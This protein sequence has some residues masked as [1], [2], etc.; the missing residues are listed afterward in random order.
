MEIGIDQELT[1]VVYTAIFGGRDKLQPPG[2]ITPGW[3][4]VCFSDE[5]LNCEGWQIKVIPV[6][7][8][9][10]DPKRNSGRIK[11]LSHEYHPNVEITL[12]M[13]ANF[14]ITCDLNQLVKAAL[15]DHDIA[16]FKHPGWNCIYREADQVIHFGLDDPQTVMDQVC[17]YRNLGYPAHGGLIASGV[18]LRRHTERVI[19]LNELWWQEVERGSK[20]DQLSFNYA[21]HQ[22]RLTYTAWQENF[23]N[24][25]KFEIRAH[26]R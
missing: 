25:P 14:S 11:I 9:L 16:S 21:A 23:C 13:D 2:K 6:E 4:Y 3:E 18:M 7:D 26:A 20:R 15:T 1:R 8:R 22:L 12:W 19:K 24:S 5:R 10:L 17:R